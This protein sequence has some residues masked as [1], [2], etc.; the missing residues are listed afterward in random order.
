MAR[1]AGWPG[2]L[3]TPVSLDASRE[4]VTQQPVGFPTHQ[5]R[6]AGLAACGDLWKLRCGV[7]LGR[8]ETG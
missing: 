8:G 4:S 5:H 2:G 7:D 3:G 6:W 1:S